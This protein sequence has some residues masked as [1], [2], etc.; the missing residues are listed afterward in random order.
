MKDILVKSD[1]SFEENKRVSY[2]KVLLLGNSI[3]LGMFFKYGMCAT[4]EK[5]DYA[6][7]LT[8]EFKKREPDCKISK[9]RSSAFEAC[10]NEGNFEIWFEDA[11][12]YFES[13]LDLVSL[14]MF[15]NVNTPKKCELFLKNF[16]ELV[17]RIRE[18]AP[19]ARIVWT[20]GWYVGLGM[21]V[22]ERAKQIADDLGVERIDVSSAHT[23]ENEA[24]EGQISLNAEG[25]PIVVPT[26]WI[27]H[28]SND[29][30]R[31]IADIMIA[32]LF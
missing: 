11:R 21:P 2:K 7:Y 32:H 29:G 5:S 25:E 17:R 19:N 18:L 10:E 6:Y 28:P 27:T 22:F 30:M 23:K 1:E 20:Y 31:E 9:F 3:L 14:Q 8:R 13:D 24:K 15:D 16:P 4:D 12:P 26:E